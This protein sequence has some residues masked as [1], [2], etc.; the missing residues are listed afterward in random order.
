MLGLGETY[1]EVLQTANDLKDCGVSFVTLGQYLRPTPSHL[2]V[3]KYI[4]PS[5]FFGYKS[6]LKKLGFL[7]VS[8]GPLVRSSFRASDISNI[9]KN[10]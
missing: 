9:I 4:H 10:Q 6:E 1:Q 5:K 2:S 7:H 8:S 3:D